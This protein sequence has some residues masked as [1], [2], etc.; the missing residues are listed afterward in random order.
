LLD[1]FV[2]LYAILRVEFSIIFTNEQEGNL[3]FKFIFHWT[4]FFKVF[5]N[6]KYQVKYL[7]IKPLKPYKIGRI[8]I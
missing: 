8:L 6:L 2:D 7:I 5:W 3:C 1:D 4:P